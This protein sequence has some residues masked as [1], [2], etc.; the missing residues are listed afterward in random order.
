MM[1]SRYV[2]QSCTVFYLRPVWPWIS[3]ESVSYGPSD[4]D[5]HGDERE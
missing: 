4:Q 2:N 5:Q 3:Q 1:S